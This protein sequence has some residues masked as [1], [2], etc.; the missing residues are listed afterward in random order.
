MN[1][2]RTATGPAI[3]PVH[4]TSDLYTLTITDRL[5]VLRPDGSTWDL[6]EW[7]DHESRTVAQVLDCLV[8]ENLASIAPPDMHGNRFEEPLR[9]VLPSVEPVVAVFYG[10]DQDFPSGRTLDETGVPLCWRAVAEAA[11]APAAQAAES[12]SCPSCH[13]GSGPDERGD[14]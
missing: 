10:P 7:H 1:I 5:D 3:Q 11:G 14:R 6:C 9:I 4:D 13:H 8:W 12:I 2:R